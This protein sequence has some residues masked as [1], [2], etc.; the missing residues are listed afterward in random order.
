MTTQAVITCNILRRSRIN[1]DISAYEQLHGAKYNWNAH[2][3]APPGTRAIIHSSTLTRTSWGP[4]GIDAW[5]CG[6]AEDHYRCSHFYV[7]DTRAMRILGSYELYPVHCQL[8]TLT[9]TEHTSQVAQELIR[10][11]K[12]LPLPI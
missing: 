4:R 3:M 2:P 6:P 5:Y 10:C 11:M 7:P 1:P 12:F 9:P 8:P